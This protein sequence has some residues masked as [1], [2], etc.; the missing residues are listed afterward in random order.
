[1][2][3][4][5]VDVRVPRV[6]AEGAPPATRVGKLEVRFDRN[7]IALDPAQDSLKAGRAAHCVMTN[8]TLHERDPS[9]GLNSAFHVP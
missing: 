4:H 9:P 1:M 3:T 2:K 7:R 5:A 8:F 6:V